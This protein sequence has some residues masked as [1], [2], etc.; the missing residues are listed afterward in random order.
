VNC[1]VTFPNYLTIAGV[2]RN[3]SKRMRCLQ[4]N[5]WQSGKRPRTTARVALGRRCPICEKPVK[6][7]NSAACSRAHSDE[8]KHKE[9]IAAWKAGSWNGNGGPAMQAASLHVRR[10]LMDTFG[11][12]CMRCGWAERH[13]VTGRVPVELDHIDGDATNNRESNLRLLCPNCHSL[14]ESYRALNKG[15]GRQ[16]RR[17][18]ERQRIR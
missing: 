4:C 5:P 2:R 18:R 12:C 7:Q 14:T 16:R 3:V 9:L 10:Y 8:A 1:S 13:P 17:E 6:R 15:Q 11:E